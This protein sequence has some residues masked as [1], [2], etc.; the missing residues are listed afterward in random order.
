MLG[1]A[2]GG[3]GPASA[4]KGPPKTEKLR[5]IVTKCQQKNENK[6]CL[7]QFCIALRIQKHTK[8]MCFFS[9]QNRRCPDGHAVV[10]TARLAL[11]CAVG[12]NKKIWWCEVPDVMHLLKYVGTQAEGR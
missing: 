3:R 4:A 12:E 2:A 8:M 5:K 11:P 7:S 9:K 10:V 1:A 6:F